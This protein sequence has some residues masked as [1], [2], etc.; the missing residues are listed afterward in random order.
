MIP[1][2]ENAWKDKG[3]E[4]EKKVSGFQGL[5]RE[6]EQEEDGCGSKRA[7]CGNS[8]QRTCLYFEYQFQYHGNEIAVEFW[9][10]GQIW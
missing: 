4:M 7:T 10:L 2:I 3:I 9:L 5:K 1:F 6:Q 8:V